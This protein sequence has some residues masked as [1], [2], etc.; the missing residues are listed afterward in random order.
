MNEDEI[1]SQLT[2]LFQET[3]DDEGIVLHPALMANDIPE[4]D[5]LSH[6]RLIVAV[7]MQFN[8]SLNASEAAELENVGQFVA[9]VAR[10][11]VR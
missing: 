1:Y 8:I 6:I 4:W 5:S 9:L 7:E 2:P 10:K 3:F 11:A